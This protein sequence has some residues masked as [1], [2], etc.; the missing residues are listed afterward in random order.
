MNAKETR[1]SRRGRGDFHAEHGQDEA[2]HSF[3]GA[4]DVRVREVLDEGSVM[5][6]LDLKTWQNTL[7]SSHSLVLSP[8]LSTDQNKHES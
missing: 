3:L 1:V 7:A 6:V 8:F 2:A 4:R 5:V